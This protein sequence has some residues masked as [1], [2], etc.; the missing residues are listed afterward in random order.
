VHNDIQEVCGSSTLATT[1]VLTFAVFKHSLDFLPDA[2]HLSVVDK[3]AFI[4]RHV[5]FY[6]GI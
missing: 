4:D 6:S 3:S 1:L 2:E 5:V